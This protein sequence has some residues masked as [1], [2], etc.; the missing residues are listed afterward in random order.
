M[1]EI[2]EINIGMIIVVNV[3]HLRPST[4]PVT[5]AFVTTENTT[6]IAHTTK[7]ILYSKIS[8]SI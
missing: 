2:V 8:W 1:Q 3:I 6:N 5:G 7:I 4:K